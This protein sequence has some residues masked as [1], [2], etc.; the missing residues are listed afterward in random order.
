MS[1]RLATEQ[2]QR[3]SN[4]TRTVSALLGRIQ[5]R[6]SMES[7]NGEIQRGGKLA[8]PS[9]GHRVAAEEAGRYSPVWP[10]MTARQAAGPNLASGA[11]AVGAPVRGS[12][13]EPRQR[14]SVP[15]AVVTMLAVAVATIAATA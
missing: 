6:E 14:R 15:V 7:E 3:K 11:D 13:T 2:G 8:G 10:A 5:S 1:R 12:R 4:G 9:I